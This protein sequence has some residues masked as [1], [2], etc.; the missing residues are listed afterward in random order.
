MCM[1]DTVNVMSSS[2]R[3][4]HVQFSFKSFEN[5]LENFSISAMRKVNSFKGKRFLMEF[6]LAST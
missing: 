3:P 5:G 1:F 4:I 2:E 6:L